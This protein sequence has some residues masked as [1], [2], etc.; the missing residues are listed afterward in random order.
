[1]AIRP[2]LTAQPARSPD[3]QSLGSSSGMRLQLDPFALPSETE[4]RF[5]MLMVAAVILA[6]SLS[7]HWI[8]VPN[9]LLM[10]FQLGADYQAEM[11]RFLEEREFDLEAFVRVAGTRQD[12]ERITELLLRQGVRLLLTLLHLGAFALFAIGILV[13]E[14]RRIQRRHRAQP[15]IHDEAPKAVAAIRE[16]ISQCG[17]R[18]E[19]NLAWKPGFLDGLAFGRLSKPTLLVAGDPTWQERSFGDLDRAV[20][21]HELGHVANQDIHYREVA[22]ALL[23]S[24]VAVLSI[25]L[26]TLIY[27]QRP[28]PAAVGLL[29]ARIIGVLG[30]IWGIWAGLIR[31]R[32]FY[33]DARV[34]TW[35]QGRL[36]RKRLSLPQ[37]FRKNFWMVGGHHPTNLDRQLV[38]Q[39]PWRLFEVSSWLP[40]LTGA[41]F[42]VLLGYAGPA[43]LD[44]QFM[45]A[46][47]FRPL[48]IG[49]SQVDFGLAVI[50]SQMEYLTYF[51]AGMVVT[52]FVFDALGVAVLRA[53]LADF[54]HQP[55]SDWGY[56]RRFKE[57]FRF[58]LG[59]ELG[60]WLTPL[61]FFG[62]QSPASM[63]AWILVA[64][65]LVWL[66]L[67]FV[68]SLGRLDLAARQ[69]APAVGSIRGL[70]WLS[71]IQL[72]F[73]VFPVAL[74]RLGIG[75][76]WDPSLAQAVK[77][78]VQSVEG[79]P[80]F[81]LMGALGSLFFGCCA[82]AI[83]AVS[84]LGIRFLKLRSSV[85][86]NCATCR[87]PH[88]RW[89]LVG[90]RCAGCGEA[91]AP[92][93]HP[94]ALSTARE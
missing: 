21:L 82:F 40:L 71:T 64:S 94:A 48:V 93:L 27:V 84:T 75:L 46:I 14:P 38:L 58:V 92:W 22:W 1:M 32:E 73:L 9:I 52:H 61:G 56:L 10:S 6:W 18:Q 15:L 2:T 19:L 88:S 78:E 43:M 76:L 16:L 41:S 25:S 30:L 69:A 7:S 47:V 33:A 86:R 51:V 85:H 50:A 54:Q 29:L 49:L 81:V 63:S 79:L 4:G 3:R 91:L 8:Q 35:G 44:L 26:A 83:V 17:V 70:R 62:W 89:R 45:T 20:V 65:F 34:V 59:L 53:S 55:A 39:E 90:R 31:L 12:V 67:I 36:L 13:L 42:A 80:S 5:R 68:R 66:W 60:F 11:V 24:L 77:P 37:A 23:I 72:S 57:A 87:Q 28:E 74:G